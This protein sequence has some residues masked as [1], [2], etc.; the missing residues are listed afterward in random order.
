MH[1][2]NPTLNVFQKKKHDFLVLADTVIIYIYFKK[3]AILSF[4]KKKTDRSFHDQGK[5]L[6]LYLQ[7]YKTGICS[8]SQLSA[9]TLYFI[10]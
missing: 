4:F 7:I 9:R 5:R 2:L 10:K 6:S 8:T 1:N 3:N